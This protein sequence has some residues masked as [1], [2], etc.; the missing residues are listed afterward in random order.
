MSEAGEA[1]A[2]TR[3]LLALNT[4]NPPG[5]EAAAIETGGRSARGR[6]IRGSPGRPGARAAEPVARIGGSDAEA[7]AL[8]FTGHLDVVPL[9]EARMAG[10]PVRRRAAGR[11]TVSAAALPT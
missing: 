5:E 1:L 10:G 9:G 11:P 8:G 3:R 2:L 4:I 7:P 6:R